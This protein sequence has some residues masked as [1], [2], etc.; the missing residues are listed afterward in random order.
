MGHLIFVNNNATLFNGGKKSLKVRFLVI[1]GLLAV[2]SV[3]A[4]GRFSPPFA[5]Y[6][7]YVVTLAGEP[8]ALASGQFHVGRVPTRF[9]PV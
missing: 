8:G 4:Q 1:L 7:N 5:A 9:W 6:R 2:I 3:L